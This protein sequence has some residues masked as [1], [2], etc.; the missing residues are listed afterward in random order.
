MA[1]ITTVISCRPGIRQLKPK[2]GT[3]WYVKVLEARA[4]METIARKVFGTELKRDLANE[5]VESYKAVTNNHLRQCEVTRINAEIYALEERDQRRHRTSP[6]G[7]PGTHAEKNLTRQ[8]E[9]V[10]F[11]IHPRMD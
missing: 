9:R 4:S 6:S 3:P 8:D 2:R 10:L 11:T 1:A 5:Y 7:I